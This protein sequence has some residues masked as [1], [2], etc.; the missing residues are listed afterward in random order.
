M[1]DRSPRF[2]TVTLNPAWDCTLRVSGSLTPG[3]VHGVAGETMTPG[4]KG[5]NVAKM[6]QANGRSVTAAGLIGVSDVGTFDAG[7]AALG[8]TPRFMTVPGVVRI[9]LMIAGTNGEMK[10]NRPGFPD[11][12]LAPR[13]LF[14]YLRELVRAGDVVVFSGSLPARFPA[15]LYRRLIR[16]V[17][18]WGGDTVLD[19]AG[20]SLR[21]AAA[22]RPDV[23]KPNRREL[24]D[25]LG[26]SLADDAAVERALR[27]LAKRHAA[28]IV[29]DGSRGAWF[30]APGAMWRGTS[31]D[32]PVIDTT[33]AGDAMLG[34]FC[35]DFFPGGKLNASVVARSLAA[36]A[37]AVEQAGTPALVMARVLA[38]ARQVKTWNKALNGP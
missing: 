21:L 13:R 34:Q 23:V 19:A 32:V 26:R 18:R 20:E 27:R 11:L 28:L 38:L 24:Q 17:R 30:A 35:A 1:K 33:G 5:I 29:S 12:D 31:P 9:N 25:W 2:I 37:A 16:A 22:A 14:A 6:L 4:G 15:D 10:F 3:R 36:G 8:V 7:V